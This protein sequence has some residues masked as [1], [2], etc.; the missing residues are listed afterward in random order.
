MDRAVADAVEVLNTCCEAD[1]PIIGFVKRPVGT[2]MAR[3][4]GMR[5]RDIVALRWMRFGEYVKWCGLDKGRPRDKLRTSV[6]REFKKYARERGIDEG[7]V[8]I[9]SYYINT[10]Y[11]LPYRVE[12]PAYFEEATEKVFA[13]L[14]AL[15]ASRGIP[16]PIYVADIYTKLTNTTRD[17]FVIALRSRLAEKVKSGEMSDEDIRLFELQLGEYL[18]LPLEEGRRLTTE[19]LA[20]RYRR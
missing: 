20:R 14:L 4:L 1:I 5:V 2:Q 7:N 17:L 16:F 13:A 19:K 10:G 3:A 12:V 11:A 18:T 15:R 6:T 9:T 8:E